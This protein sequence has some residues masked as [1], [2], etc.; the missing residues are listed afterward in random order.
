MAQSL[1]QD[2]SNELAKIVFSDIQTKRGKY[3]YFLG[4][5]EPW[6]GIGG[7]NA[8]DKSPT[9]E[10]AQ[11]L[12]VDRAFRSEIAFVKQISANDVSL[13]VRKIEWESGKVFDEWDHTQPM[14][15][16]DF[17]VITSDYNVYKCLDNGNGAPS[18]VQPTGNRIYP[19][20]T[21]DGY[22]W[23]Y[24]YNVPPYKRVRFSSVTHIP[25]QKALSDSFY[26]NGAIESVAI[27]SEGTG[28]TDAQLTSISV[29]T[30]TLTGSGASASVVVD[31]FGTI[32]QIIVINGGTGYTKGARIVIS[33][34]GT[35]SGAS[36]K[37]I[38]VT[39]GAI[40]AIQ[41]LSG[42]VG[43][44]PETTTVQFIVGGAQLL[45]VISSDGEIVDVKIL[46][47]G[48][49]YNTAPELEVLVEEEGNPYPGTSTGKYGNP[50]AILECIVFEGSIRHVNIIDP[51]VNYPSDDA[52]SITIQ[53]DGSG[54][55]LKPVISSGK[56]VDVVVE[57]PGAGYSTAILTV[58]SGTGEG[59]KLEATISQSD[60]ISDQMVIE[61][62]TVQGAIYN[63][64]V[65]NEGA[66]YSSSSTSVSITGNGTGCTAVPVILDG[67]VVDIVVTNPGS[68]YTYAEVE[69]IDNGRAFV[70]FESQAFAY[71]IL[72]PLNGHG[73]D[74]VQELLCDTL[75]INTS[76]RGE[77]QIEGVTQE[78][79]N[80]GIIRNPRDLFSGERY[81][82]SSE[83]LVYIMKFSSTVGLIKDE[84]LLFGKDKFRILEIS[85]SN[86]SL[87]P[88]DRDDV[89]PIGALI[90]EN[91]GA[92]YQAVE[93]VKPL[94]FDKYSGSLL[95]LSTENPFS[96]AS[97][98]SITIKTFIKL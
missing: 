83:V 57:N 49:G 69:V 8:D 5:V 18:T 85:G 59:A 66:G 82:K 84:I 88:I 3:Y 63:I 56:I 43:Y 24:M 93:V 89:V 48:I 92:N 95:Y 41:V 39:D 54:A 34:S 44:S 98:Q 87:I 96:F 70:P 32:Q 15:G 46:D 16:K 64:K 79:R 14:T 52:T 9:N 75:A 50:T 10:I 61:Q 86:V 38:G 62:T 37:V 97:D 29:A 47:A 35:G 25:V 53:G 71:A 67:R 12:D 36:A 65:T 20:D 4:G 72:P 68:G 31:S 91:T 30:N 51:G 55:V 17:Y 73:F 6:N 22:K 74:A 42:G 58:Q 90:S 33:S 45:P 27:I 81:S 77:L 76:L 7:S 40:T 1:R 23:K 78:Y 13:A 19:F 26:N 60:L 11:T 80:F 2:F 21:A 94:E 28:Y